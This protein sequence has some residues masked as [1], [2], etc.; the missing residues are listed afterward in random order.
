MADEKTRQMPPMGGPGRRGGMVGKP[1]VKVN[2]ETVKR[3]FSYFGSFKYSEIVCINDYE[4]SAVNR[5]IKSVNAVNKNIL[6]FL[7][8]KKLFGAR[9]KIGIFCIG[10]YFYIDSKIH[11]KACYTDT[12]TDRVEVWVAVSHNDDV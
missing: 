12:S 11:S 5:F 10:N 9:R 8:L 6:I 7:K 3:L 2:K 1:D 4:Q